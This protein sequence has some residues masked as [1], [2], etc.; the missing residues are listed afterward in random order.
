MGAA[1]KAT[2]GRSGGAIHA[3]NIRDRIGINTE[4]IEAIR[5]PHI[6]RLCGVLA[7]DGMVG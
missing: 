3:L 7:E 5:Q 6:Q 2:R 4:L 1:A